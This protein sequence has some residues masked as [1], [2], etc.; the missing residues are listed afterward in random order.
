MFVENGCNNHIERTE[1]ENNEMT[2]KNDNKDKETRKQ[3]KETYDTIHI[4]DE[5]GKRTNIAGSN[6][7]TET[8]VNVSCDGS[9]ETDVKDPKDTKG[10]KNP[11]QMCRR[12]T[13]K[14]AILFKNNDASKNDPKNEERNH[15]DVRDKLKRIKDTYACIVKKHTKQ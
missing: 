1:H 15:I 3:Q 7:D 12:D 2:V 5:S 6:D 11:K 13:S 9:K 14:Q 10:S 4:Y 8:T